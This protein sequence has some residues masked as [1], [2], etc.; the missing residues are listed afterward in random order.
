MTYLLAR[1]V[2]LFSPSFTILPSCLFTVGGS[3]SSQQVP[4]YADFLL[5]SLGSRSPGT[6][7]PP[8]GRQSYPAGPPQLPPT[9]GQH[10]LQQHKQHQQQQQQAQSTTPSPSAA[11]NFSKLIT[12]KLLC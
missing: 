9:R 11:P 10:H 5:G 8:V 4:S 7:A 6:A 3:T 12:L 2:Y 1:S